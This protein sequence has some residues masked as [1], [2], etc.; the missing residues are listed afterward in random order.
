MSIPHSSAR[1]VATT[2]RRSNAIETTFQFDSTRS[3][4]SSLKFDSPIAVR[5]AVT[6]P[7]DGQES[8]GTSDAPIVPSS[9]VLRR[10]Q[11]PVETPHTYSDRDT[12]KLDRAADFWSPPDATT[13]ITII[14]RD[15]TGEDHIPPSRLLSVSPIPE[16][17][18]PPSPERVFSASDAV[19]PVSGHSQVFYPINPAHKMASLLN[20]V[21]ITERPS[22]PVPSDDDDEDE[23][24]AY[25]P[26]LLPPRPTNPTAYAEFD[27][28]ESD[29]EYLDDFASPAKSPSVAAPSYA[30]FDSP[31]SDNGDASSWDADDEDDQSFVGGRDLVVART[32]HF[33][34]RPES[35][36]K[37]FLDMSADSD[38]EDEDEYLSSDRNALIFDDG[39]FMAEPVYRARRAPDL[40]ESVLDRAASSRESSDSESISRTD[41]LFAVMRYQKQHPHESGRQN[42]V[43]LDDVFN[44]D[45]R[46]DLFTH[47][48][49]EEHPYTIQDSYILPTNSATQQFY[50][51]QN[52]SHFPHLQYEHCCTGSVHL[53]QTHSFAPLPPKSEPE[54]ST[55]SLPSSRRS[56]R[57]TAGRIVRGLTKSLHGAL[58]NTGGGD[59]KGKKRM[60]LPD[61]E[62][63][64][65]SSSTS[66]LPPFRLKRSKKN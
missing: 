58:T 50:A 59:A 34:P 63:S 42:P 54:S 6:A 19:E 7:L 43:L 62:A 13:T 10:P 65:N 53:Y 56:T 36:L 31:V 12:R 29:D 52:P 24:P 57:S 22:T 18:V 51:C 35:P 39:E 40:M 38:E 32:L 23:A 3:A 45:V 55:S 30:Y 20:P 14:E 41:E 66:L 2:R 48:E 1:P 44:P 47:P 15:S 8:A 16:D 27:D 33:E 64:P 46:V 60:R 61:S 21:E 28:E 25:L 49:P 17:E 26:S 11:R 5:V 9:R 37:S 4:S